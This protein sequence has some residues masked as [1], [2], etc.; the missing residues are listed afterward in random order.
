MSEPSGRPAGRWPPVRYLVVAAVSVFAAWA[1]LDLLVGGLHVLLLAFFA[2][3]IASILNIPVTLLSRYVPRGLATF[4]VFLGVIG[5]FTG[6]VAMSAP[7]ISAEG[8]RLLDQFPDALERIRAWLRGAP[9]G[10][11]TGVPNPEQI[12]RTVED[13]VRDEIYGFVGKAVPLAIW[14]LSG[15]ASTLFVFI[16]SLFLV[17]DPTAYRRAILRLVPR[18]RE[19]S[20]GVFL[21]RA[22][23]ALQH[24][25]VGTVVSMTVVAVMTAVGLYAIGV[26]AWLTL[27]VLMFFGEFVPYV[28]PVVAAVPGIAAALAESPTL[29]LYAT[30]V[31][32]AVQQLEG[33]LIAPLIMK[34]AVN[35]KPGVLLVWQIFVGATVGF[36]AVV[37]ATPLLVCVQ[38]AVGHFYMERTLGKAGGS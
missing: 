26:D 36:L 32:V 29:A 38:V 13:R 3:L 5:L 34:R 19:E 12:T 8:Q 2:L 22:G 6:L 17:Y 24:W 4:F 18:A 28:G 7:I 16:L 11:L 31:Y 37:V 1:A 30:L 27:A 20:M 35:I 21:D 33:T 23:V 9:D 15:L 25:M 14:T 10:A